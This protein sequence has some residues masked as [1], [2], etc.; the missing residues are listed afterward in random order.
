ML[1]RANI[2]APNVLG[3]PLS[4]SPA[5]NVADDKEI[6]IIYHV[7]AGFALLWYEDEIFPLKERLVD[8]DSQWFCHCSWRPPDKWLWKEQSMGQRKACLPLYFKT[9]S[10]VQVQVQVGSALGRCASQCWKWRSS[11]RKVVHSVEENSP[12]EP[13]FSIGKCDP[14]MECLVKTLTEY[15]QQ[16]QKRGS[17][18]GQ[19]EAR[20]VGSE[21]LL[22]S[23]T[24]PCRLWALTSF[25]YSSPGA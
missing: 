9:P 1:V 13:R 18:G 2:D 19:V 8:H 14:V 10:A 21:H 20:R 4:L 5:T 12:T 22:P 16:K 15:W 24:P 23:S 17:L 6:S 7:D 25:K 3:A 11:I